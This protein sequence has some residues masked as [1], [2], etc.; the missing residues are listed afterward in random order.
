MVNIPKTTDIK[1]N[2]RPV[3]ISICHNYA[4]EGPCRFEGGDNLKKEYDLNVNAEENEKFINKVRATFP[5]DDANILNPVH[6]QVDESFFVDEKDVDEIGKGHQ[7]VDLY[8][9]STRAGNTLLEFAQ[10]YKK[11]IMPLFG[12]RTTAAFLAR[13]LEVYPC[14]TWGDA[15]ELIKVLRLRKA[16]AE[17]RA[18]TL[19]RMNS[20]T[21]PG[22]LDSFTSL[23][24]VTTRLGTRFVHYNI[25]EFID[26][27]LN[28]P[29]DTNPT[30]PGKHEPNINDKDEVEINR[31][32]DEFIGGA[33][34]CDMKRENV[35]PS[36]KAHYLVNKLL[37]KLGCNAFT[38]PC[39]DICATR[40]LNE[41]RFTFCLNHSLNNENGISSACEHDTCA[42][43]S[44]VVLS[45]AAKAP[46]Y[47]GNTNVNPLKNGVR[48]QGVRPLAEGIIGELED[49]ENLVL[50]WHSVP[51][52]KLKGYNTK[53]APYA[54]RSF[55]H[56][57]WGA[58]IRYDFNQDKGQKITM[59][60]FDPSC[61]KLFVAKGNIVGGTGYNDVNCSEG[62]FFQVK[63]AR[64]FFE[65]QSLVGIHIPLVYGDCFERI[66][67]LG[68]ILGLEVLTA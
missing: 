17:T 40:R 8:F 33:V 25:H 10:K 63:D 24:N 18:L 6:I 62:V 2:V 19:V 38:V 16:L 46:A 28:V 32:T 26:Q 7:N 56:S 21:A 47:M 58:T 50:T 4:F 36:M 61:T 45:N 59:C 23:E 15:V 3:K 55:T 35:Y 53:T 54:I 44:M 34:E 13:G 30:T 1:L 39:F 14:E 20:T 66:V 49:I 51:N 67:K 68:K 64:D 60:R 52:R 29:D 42:L 31:M 9:V 48:T 22:M 37:A 41:E 12:P 57:G 65:K 11:P 5:A 43:L 27:T